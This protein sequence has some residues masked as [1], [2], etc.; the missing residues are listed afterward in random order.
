[1]HRQE[2]KYSDCNRNLREMDYLLSL[3]GEAGDINSSMVKM[4]DDYE[5]D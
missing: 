5:Y 1:M 2:H 3:R 4:K